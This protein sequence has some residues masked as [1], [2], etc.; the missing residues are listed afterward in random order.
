M[1]ALTGTSEKDTALQVGFIVFSSN[2]KYR[3]NLVASLRS[4]AVQGGEDEIQV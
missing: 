2:T 4:S 1:I 3:E